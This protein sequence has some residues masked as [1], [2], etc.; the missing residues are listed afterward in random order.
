ME[1]EENIY[2]KEFIERLN[3]Q[4][5]TNAKSPL[6][7]NQ[8]FKFGLVALIVLVLVGGIVL[9]LSVVSTTRANNRVNFIKNLRI[10]GDQSYNITKQYQ[11]KINSVKIRIINEH[12]F[13]SVTGMNNDVSAYVEKIYTKEQK[14]KL[15]KE[16]SSRKESL[17]AI[18][19]RLTKADLNENLTRTYIQELSAILD[20]V[21]D[22]IYKVVNS[23]FYN[24]DFTATMEK[25][26]NQ[27][28]K[29]QSE[30]KE[31]EN[32]KPS[33]GTTKPAKSN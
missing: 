14:T 20:Q 18:T 8:T 10:I 32:A 12:F 24:R 29:I 26:Y 17:K 7:K 27:M 19:E 21:I 28:L 23:K 25:H 6:A 30:I 9:A 22:A 11:N 3:N 5:A 1:N 4:P 16:I 33:T 31:L 2:S 13:Q 15:N